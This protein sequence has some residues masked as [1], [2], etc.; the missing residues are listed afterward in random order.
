MLHG[1][2]ARNHFLIANCTSL[3]W[4][5]A[6][7]THLCLL[8]LFI[9]YTA[10]VSLCQIVPLSR[11]YEIVVGNFSPCHLR[12]LAWMR[13]MVW[14]RAACPHP[15]HH[16]RTCELP[17]G[18]E[19]SPGLALENSCAI[20]NFFIHSSFPLSQGKRTP[21]FANLIQERRNGMI[22]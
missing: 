7:A 11:V 2:G 9:N 19:V 21:K 13:M 15:H 12:W 16:P 4:T 14:M 6:L 1:L 22:S 18:S 17:Q 8:I 10:S 3:F 5:N 20:Y